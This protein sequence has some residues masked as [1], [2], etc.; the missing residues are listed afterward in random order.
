MEG[1]PEE[2]S[3]TKKYQ[4]GIKF[5]SLC[6]ECNNKV[7]GAN[8]DKVLEEFANQLA[9]IMQTSIALPPVVKVPIKINR[10]CRA[11]CGHMLAAK[12]FY[13]NE[14]LIDK[15]LREY[16]LDETK[17]PPKKMSLLYWIYPYSTIAI[18]RDICVYPSHNKY[19]IP[20]GLISIMNSFPAA[21]IIADDEERCGLF[22]LFSVCSNDIDETVEIPVD[23]SSCYFPGTKHLRPLAWPCN[24][25]DEEDGASFMLG[26][27]KC[28]NDSKIAK[29]SNDNIE[30][31]RNRRK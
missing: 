3:Y 28:M 25:S 24:I 29:H 27:D 15:E 11:I 12:N 6:D 13:E 8:Y 18:M 17:L 16:V 21:Y 31:I 4:N 2:S 9:I 22:D 30:K 26:V 10:L 14:C 19:K 23:C 20:K 7:L 5:R 1:I